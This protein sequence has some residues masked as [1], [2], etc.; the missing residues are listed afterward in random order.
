MSLLFC[1]PLIPLLLFLPS[2]LLSIYVHYPCTLPQSVAIAH[3]GEDVLC[4]L[5]IRLLPS[6]LSNNPVLS[7]VMMVT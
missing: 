5:T 1:H 4:E 6:N 2:P 7:E 3:Y